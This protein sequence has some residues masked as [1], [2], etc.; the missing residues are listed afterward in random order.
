M[1]ADGRRFVPGQGNNAYIFPGVALGALAVGAKRLDDKSF[2]LAAVALAEQTTAADREVGRVY[3]PLNDIRSVSA[4]VAA[5]V[6]AHAHATGVAS[7]APPGDMVA[8]CKRA[9]WNPGEDRTA[10]L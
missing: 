5:A 3:P 6:A 7:V 2:Y 8:F 9:Q 4:H 10:K 1:L